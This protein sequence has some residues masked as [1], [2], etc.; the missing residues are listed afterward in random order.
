V[1]VTRDQLAT[2]HAAASV[3]SV[4]VTWPS[5]PAAG[6]KALITLAISNATSNGVTLVQD[7]GTSVS[8]FTADLSIPP[9]SGTRAG[10]YIFRADGISLP[11]SGSYT[12]TITLAGSVPTIT[13]AG[14]TYLGVSTGA[15]TGTNNNSGTGSSVTSGNVT[16]AVTGALIFGAMDDDTSANPESI[17]L[18]TSGANAVYTQANG[19]GF[20]C[21]A[22]ADHIATTTSAQGLAWTLG[23]TPDWGAWAAV[24]SPSSAVA[25]PAAA[26][27]A[28][29]GTLTAGAVVSV[30]AAASLSGTGTLTAAPTVA[31]PSAAALYGTGTLT[32]GAVVTAIGQ[33]SA[34]LSGTGTLTVAGGLGWSAAVNLA[35]TGTL[36]PVYT[37]LMLQ[38]VPLA[39]TGTLTVAPVTALKF[40]AGLFGAGFLSIPQVAGGLVSG[41][42][43]AGTPQALPGSSQVAVAPPGSSNWQWLGTLG[44]VTALT[45][46]FVCPGG[47][48]KLTCT[49]QVPASYRTQLF[50]PGWQVKVTRGGHQVW[51]GKL[52]EPQ[53]SPH[54]WTLTAV[55][56]GN[57]GTDYLAVYSGT[58]PSGQPDA[59]VN[60]A[61][62]R[63][64]PWGN[65]GIGTPS[66]IWLGQSV[67][68]GA[69][70]I[71]GLLNLVTSRGGLTWYV[72]SQPGGL[73]GADD[74]SVFPLPAV[75]NRLLVATNPVGRTLGGDTNTIVIRY[76]S[77]SENA[78]T[79]T[80]ATYATVTAVNAQSV[81]AHGTLEQ[82][83]DIS[84]AGL[85]SSA[86]ATAVGTNA[87]LLFQRAS[88]AGPFQASYGQ[89]LNMGGAPV[90]PGCDQ[91]GNVVKMLLYD[92]GL[93]GEVVPGPITWIVGAYEWN[94]FTQ[95]ATLTP[96]QVLEQSLGSLL[97]AGH[98]SLMPVAVA[99]T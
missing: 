34:S 67:D 50:N 64:L 63:G 11:A 2:G 99:S 58:W 52:D 9:V 21:F 42:G 65:P 75:P 28:G 85:L 55:G 33:G 83:I 77:G 82:Y 37:G 19:A 69:Q 54:G 29:T 51:A 59:A 22:A 47:A 57:R 39:G 15:P 18:T 14:C 24:Y 76:Q 78:T 86:A 17:T 62:G 80:T 3:T 73:Y 1:A 6:S 71:T 97:A 30:P 25:H 61:I 43:G 4:T 41:V 44:Q 93:G 95:Q 49:V 46:S 27:L 88:F 72:N 68:S 36:T 35:G 87:L 31:I 74:L 96:M 60:A 10:K 13:A 5:L 40:T 7:N 94:D 8:T 23:D 66:G 92:W 20:L 45:Y 70:T 38:A 89:L 53:P 48:D 81:A 79:G 56:N 98:S 12:V 26:A 16:P 91:A 32:A 84:D 90:D